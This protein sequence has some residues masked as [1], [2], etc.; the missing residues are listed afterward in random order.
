MLHQYGA[1]WV[2]GPGGGRSPMQHSPLYA[3]QARPNGVYGMMNGQPAYMVG[4]QHARVPPPQGCRP[5]GYGQQFA[6]Q[7]QGYPVGFIFVQLLSL[8]CLRHCQC[9]D[10]WTSLK[11]IYELNS[12]SVLYG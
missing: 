3:G 11:A 6:G 9:V 5:P 10:T 4:G 2:G 8:S 7:V 1:Q 12:S